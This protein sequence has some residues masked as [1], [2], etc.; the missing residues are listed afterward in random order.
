MDI[1][2]T[3]VFNASGHWWF[4]G[5]L[6]ALI[7]KFCNPAYLIN[8]ID[9]LLLCHYRLVYLTKYNEPTFLMASSFF[10]ASV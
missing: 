7:G 5:L 2:S 10:R 1:S 6:V 4:D 3:E 8:Y 9:W